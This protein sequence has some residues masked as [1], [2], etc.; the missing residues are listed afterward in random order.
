IRFN[1]WH[2]ADTALWASLVSH[3]L[4][5]LAA[6]VN[7]SKRPEEQRKELLKELESAKDLRSRAEADKAQVDED[8]RKRAAELQELHQQRQQKEVQLRDLKANDLRTL[9]EKDPAAKKAL[10]DALTAMGVPSLMDS[11]NNLSAALQETR[12]T[13]TRLAVLFNAV[14]K[15]KP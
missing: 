3:I 13:R 10:D 7:P 4:E 5:Q 15:T 8:V 2:Y 12:T 11:F 1:A 6:Y 9:L 14:F